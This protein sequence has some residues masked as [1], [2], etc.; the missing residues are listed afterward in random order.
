MKK[1]ILKIFSYV[2][3]CVAWRLKPCTTRT[4]SGI[5]N[6][7]HTRKLSDSSY[8]NDL[9]GETIE[10]GEVQVSVDGTMQVFGW[11]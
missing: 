5:Q 10:S 7:D 3:E 4:F 1:L 9:D 2:C 8:S 6:D 11:C